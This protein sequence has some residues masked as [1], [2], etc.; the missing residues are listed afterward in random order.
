LLITN[1]LSRVLTVAVLLGVGA[2]PGAG[3]MAV[4]RREDAAEGAREEVKGTIMVTA[5]GGALVRGEGIAAPVKD[6]KAAAAVAASVAAAR[7]AEVVEQG[8][9]GDAVG[10]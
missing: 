2:F 10:S 3:A 8:H 9:D 4:G 5:D 1:E 7:L 6:V